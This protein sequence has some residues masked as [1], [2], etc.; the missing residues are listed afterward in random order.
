MKQMQIIQHL[1]CDLNPTARICKKQDLEFNYAINQLQYSQFDFKA[2]YKNDFLFWYECWCNVAEH[3][4]SKKE[5]K[6]SQRVYGKCMTSIFLI[7]TI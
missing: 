2:N 1:V 4:I 6:V 5:K 7:A 3:V